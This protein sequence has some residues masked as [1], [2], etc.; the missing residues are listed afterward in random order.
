MTGH[1]LNVWSRSLGFDNLAVVSL[2]KKMIQPLNNGRQVIKK[3]WRLSPAEHVSLTG[4]HQ[5][6]LGCWSCSGRPAPSNSLSFL[7]SK[8]TRSK[9]VRWIKSFTKIPPPTWQFRLNASKNTKN[10]KNTEKSEK[11]RKNTKKQEKSEKNQ[12]KQQIR[13]TRKN[14]KKT[15]NIRK[16]RKNTKKKL[17]NPKKS[18]K[19][20]KPK[21]FFEDLKSVFGSEQ[22]LAKII[23]KKYSRTCKTRFKQ[24]VQS[25]RVQLNSLFSRDTYNWTFSAGGRIRTC[26]LRE[27]LI[28]SQTP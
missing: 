18:K 20:N 16:I 17:I 6:V 24:N 15:V 9:M 2:K 7:V 10:P 28:S 13:K 11:T 14:T 19:F 27:N 21:D 4:C 3:E 12:K 23:S 8:G 25:Y 22:P 5:P 1:P 26:A